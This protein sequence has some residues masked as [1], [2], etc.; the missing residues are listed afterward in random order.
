M[1]SPVD[2]CAELYQSMRV[3]VAQPRNEGLFKGEPFDELPSKRMIADLNQESGRAGVIYREIKRRITEL[4]YKPGEK[5]SESR[6]AEELGCGRSP[7]RTA[8]S[9]LQNEGW[10]E[11]SPQSGTFVRGL[12]Q[13]EIDEIF[14]ARL[15]LEA[16]L[17]GRAAKRMNELEM[18]RFRRALAAYGKRVPADRMDE[19]LELDLQFHLAIYKAASNKPLADVLLN[20]TDKSRWIRLMRKGSTTRMSDA[21][22]EIRD[23][24]DALEA[25]DEKAAAAAM[26]THIEN[27]IR[28]SNQRT[29]SPPKHK[30]A[31]AKTPKNGRVAAPTK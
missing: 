17:A 22:G 12:S 4:V 8:F 30:G 28:Q 18:R 10:I 24:L 27:M 2:Q 11:I 15:L 7:V 26:H 29:Q 14:E 21:L 16:Y 20:L 5:I 3:A 13:A 6:I 25:R 31:N 23:V 9:R 1:R 19:F